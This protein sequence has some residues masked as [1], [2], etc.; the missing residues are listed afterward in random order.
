MLL[1]LQHTIYTSHIQCNSNGSL[2]NHCTLDITR[3]KAG[4]VRYGTSRPPFVSYGTSRGDFVRKNRRTNHKCN[5]RSARTTHE[6]HE[7]SRTA[8]TIWRSARNIKWA[9]LNNKWTDFVLFMFM[10]FTKPMIYRCA[11]ARFVRN[12]CVRKICARSALV[13]EI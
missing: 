10:E 4:F 2:T 6:P 7:P 13:R 8:R 3:S 9:S 1:P 5:L 11:R 12:F